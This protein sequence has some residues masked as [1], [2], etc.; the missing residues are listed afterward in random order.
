M[1]HAHEYRCA[2]IVPMCLCVS[3]C[4]CACQS[5]CTCIPMTLCACLVQRARMY[6]L[7]DGI[8]VSHPNAPPAMPEH[9]E[10]AALTKLWNAIIPSHDRIPPCRGSMARGPYIWFPR[11]SAIDT[12]DSQNC[13]SS[14]ERRPSGPQKRIKYKQTKKGLLPALLRFFAGAGCSRDFLLMQAASNAPN[15][16]SGPLRLSPSRYLR[17]RVNPTTVVTL[18]RRRRCPRRSSRAQAQA[19][20]DCWGR[21]PAHSHKGPDHLCR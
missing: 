11:P 10:Q 15:C 2:R 7:H 1:A 18:R 3:I 4:F 9:H 17:S 19:V 21:Y 20:L 12:G 16:P 6:V 5:H 13:K 14:S 8:C